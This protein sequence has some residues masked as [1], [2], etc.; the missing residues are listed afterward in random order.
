MMKTLQIE[1][2]AS[3]YGGGPIDPNSG[4]YQ[5]GKM[6]GTA[7]KDFGEVVGAIAGTVWLVATG[8]AS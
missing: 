6:V 2:V 5:A 3:V 7:V 1:D 4:A 8:S